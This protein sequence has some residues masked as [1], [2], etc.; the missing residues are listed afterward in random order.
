M[1]GVNGLSV[2]VP[3]SEFAAVVN[4][5]ISPQSG[6][7]NVTVAA[8]QDIPEKSIREIF[9]EIMNTHTAATYD[10]WVNDVTDAYKRK[11]VE[12]QSNSSNAS[13]NIN[14]VSSSTFNVINGVS[15]SK[16]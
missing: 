7:S 10:K 14:G 11:F 13:N 3:S 16:K 1:N 9:H 8:L 15:N 5:N 12:V 4:S 6:I 2:V